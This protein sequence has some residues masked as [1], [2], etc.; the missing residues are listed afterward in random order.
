MKKLAKKIDKSADIHMIELSNHTR[1]ILWD[2]IVD[3]CLDI[4]DNRK[5]E[6]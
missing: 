4:R 3:L 6:K 1:K 2:F 5:E